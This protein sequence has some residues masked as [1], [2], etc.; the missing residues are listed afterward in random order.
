MDSQGRVVIGLLDGRLLRRKGKKDWEL[1]ANT[2]GRPLGLHFAPSGAL[3]VADA[4]KGLLSV[5]AQGK[6]TVLSTEHGGTRFAFTDDLDIAK[7]GTIYFSD[8]SHRFGVHEYKLD[9]FEHRPSGRLLSYTASTATTRLLMDGLYFANGVAIS[10]D[11]RFLLVVETAKY[12]VLRYWLAGPKAGK[13]EVFIDNLPGFPDGISAG[14]KLFWLAIASPRTALLDRSMPSPWMRKVM[15]RLPDALRP[16]PQRHGFVL[17]LDENGRVVHNLQDPSPG[18]FSP[19][20][21]VQE[22]GEKLYLGSLSA[23]EF[24]RYPRPG[25]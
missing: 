10:P 4:D 23:P 1:I 15:T 20:T 19:I 18:S 12:R 5:D 6:I 7:D 21:S 22:V 14:K 3:I 8:A 11:Q 17:G 13:H 2:G 24:A 25:E 16:A 9:L